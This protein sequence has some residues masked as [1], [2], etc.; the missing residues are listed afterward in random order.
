ME[1]GLLIYLYDEIFPYRVV[2]CRTRKTHVRKRNLS[3]QV[4]YGIKQ[5]GLIL[6]SQNQFVPTKE[7]VCS[8]Q[9]KGGVAQAIYMHV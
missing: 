1:T 4:V 6:S 9:G 8:G 7:T 5:T 2:P 3:V